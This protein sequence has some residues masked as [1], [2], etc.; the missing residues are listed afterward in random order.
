VAL[1]EDATKL[2]TALSKP[3]DVITKMA[4]QVTPI[5]TFTKEK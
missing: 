2:V 3:E 5:R 4:Y 1:L